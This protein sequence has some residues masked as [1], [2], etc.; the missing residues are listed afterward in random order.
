MNTPIVGRAEAVNGPAMRRLVE[1]RKQPASLKPRPEANKSA[2]Q[3]AA[4][5]DEGMK[6][7]PAKDEL[8]DNE[9][10]K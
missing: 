6:D 8:K 7:M 3:P 2:T 9:N 4:R 1:A 5:T 10:P